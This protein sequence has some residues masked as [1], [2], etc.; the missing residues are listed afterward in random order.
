MLDD[1]THHLAVLNP[2]PDLL[3]ERVLRIVVLAREVDVD[4]G[5]LACEDLCVLAVLAE[6]DGRAVDLVEEDCGEGADDLEGEVGAFDDVDG[7]DE[8]V[9]DDGGA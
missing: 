3:R 2:A 7:G 8:R 9:D 5:A 1:L 4:A 6:V